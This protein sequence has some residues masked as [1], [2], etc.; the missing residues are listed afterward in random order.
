MIYKIF[1]FKLLFPADYY[2]NG[3]VIPQ[4]LPLSAKLNNRKST[5]KLITTLQ[6]VKMLQYSDYDSDCDC[7]PTKHLPLP[8][9]IR[10]EILQEYH[11]QTEL[12]FTIVLEL[13]IMYTYPNE[14]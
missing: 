14:Y 5:L 11:Y 2:I 12:Y 9:L 4:E 3:Y 1:T 8:L 7:D 6:I 10:Q 13:S